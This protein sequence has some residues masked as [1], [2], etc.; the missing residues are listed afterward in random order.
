MY[1]LTN[2]DNVIIEISNIYERDEE[3]RNI[4][5]DNHN[6]AYAPDEQINVYEV[7]NIDGNITET[8][9]CYTEEKGFYENA[10]Y[11]EP[12]PTDTK[13]IQQ[14]Q[15]QVEK[16]TKEKEEL[17]EQITEIQLALVESDMEV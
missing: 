11:R 12:E 13:K 17:A 7:E 4:K 1:I 14:L 9:Y 6:I 16:I 15:E 10:D 5:V 2:K 3:Y 8:K